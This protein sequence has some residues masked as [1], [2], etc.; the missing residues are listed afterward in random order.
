[1]TRE[2]II[3]GVGT[4]RATVA[5][6][7]CVHRH[8][9]ISPSW[10]VQCAREAWQSPHEQ[11]NAIC[12]FARSAGGPVRATSRSNR[13]ARSAT[14]LAINWGVTT[15]SLAMPGSDG[16]PAARLLRD[17]VLRSCGEDRFET[18]ASCAGS[19]SNPRSRSQPVSGDLSLDSDRPISWPCSLG[20]AASGVGRISK[21]KQFDLRL[22]RSLFYL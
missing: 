14:G 7:R 13:V 3:A 22:K 6:S 21:L 15:P 16:V 11:R 12:V 19:R 17:P 10:C 20:S 1:M 2:L 18:S 4:G 9:G 8:R 5:R